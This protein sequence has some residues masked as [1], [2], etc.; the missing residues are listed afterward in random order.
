MG[1]P[2]PSNYNEGHFSPQGTRQEL[3]D[4]MKASDRKCLA[5]GIIAA[6]LFGLTLT[7]L[8]QSKTEDTKDTKDTR[9]IAAFRLSTDGLTKFSNA[10]K[11]LKE[12]GKKNPSLKEKVDNSDAGEQTIDETVGIYERHPE[13]VNAIKSAGLT[14]RQFIVTSYALVI[15]GM[16]LA[17]RKLG[18]TRDI[19]AG[20]STANM[21]FIESHQKEIEALNPDRDKAT[22]KDDE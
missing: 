5:R 15:N 22:E 6:L 14:P 4:G 16:A 18:M 3:E 9:E 10:A 19:P 1:V 20:A 2:S 12:L 7:A 13:L 8:A 11:A 17:Y 21:N